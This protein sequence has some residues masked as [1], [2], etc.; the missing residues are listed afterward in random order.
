MLFLLVVAVFFM[1]A[2][3]DNR[4]AI[5]FIITAFVIGASAID[6]RQKEYFNERINEL[7]KRIIK[8]ESEHK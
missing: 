7:E 8:F 5:V 6:K 1:F 4:W 2:D 3:V